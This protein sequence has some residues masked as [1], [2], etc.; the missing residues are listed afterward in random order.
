MTPPIKLCFIKKNLDKDYYFS[1]KID[2]TQSNETERCCYY[3][4]INSTAFPLFIWPAKSIIRWVSFR[5]V[6]RIHCRLFT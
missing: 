5:I 3:E 4:I 1:F 2:I 6:L